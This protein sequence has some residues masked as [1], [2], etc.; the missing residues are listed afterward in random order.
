MLM[1][2]LHEKTTLSLCSQ[3]EKSRNH[4]TNVGHDTWRWLDRSLKPLQHSSKE[5]PSQTPETW[6]HF[7]AGGA[8]KHHLHLQHMCD[9]QMQNATAWSAIETSCNVEREGG[10]LCMVERY[11]SIICFHLTHT[12]R[13][14]NLTLGHNLF[15]GNICP[16]FVNGADQVW[17]AQ[18]AQMSHNSWHL[19]QE[20]SPNK[21]LSNACWY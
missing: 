12:R 7:I 11:C 20:A 8:M 16:T 10:T 5:L 6:P 2:H 15:S 4:L 13:P 14:V 18:G 19:R 9:P 1:K 21:V 17:V 3:D